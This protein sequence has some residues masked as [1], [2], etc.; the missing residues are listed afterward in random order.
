MKKIL[1]I[2]C[3]V[4]LVF[5]AAAMAQEPV[6]YVEDGTGLVPDNEWTH[7]EVYTFLGGLTLEPGTYDLVFEL[8]GTA[9]CEVDGNPC[10][11]GDA[12][13]EILVQALVDGNEVASTIKGDISGSSP[14]PFTVVLEIDFHADTTVNLSINSWE[15]VS[16]PPTEK[17]QVD[18][19]T[20]T[21]TFE[22]GPPGLEER[23][24]ILE[25]QMETLMQNYTDLQQQYMELEEALSNH[26][27][28]YLTGPGEGHNI[29]E[30][31][32]EPPTP[33]TEQ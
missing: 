23:V 14:V 19:A 21:G 24:S 4:L 13:D 6:N 12:G 7:G 11:W 26:T 18:G 28:I 31:E 32:T 25:S 10:S 3:V 2:L 22:P 20:L 29:L 17:W 9:L 5:S 30:A 8:Q 16:D 33:E 1:L 15:L 27:H